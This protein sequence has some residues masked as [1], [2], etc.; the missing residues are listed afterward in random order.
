MRYI[1]AVAAIALT[2][3]SS[4][5]SLYRSNKPANTP[6]Q[7]DVIESAD[8]RRRLLIHLADLFFQ[9]HP[10]ENLFDPVFLGF[11]KLSHIILHAEHMVRGTRGEFRAG[12]FS[13]AIRLF[14]LGTNSR[15]NS[16]VTDIFCVRRRLQRVLR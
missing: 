9:R 12:K 3:S 8:D 11:G 13:A 5:C 16:W 7:V 4:G 1:A 6:G 14:G 10:A 15:V 2:V